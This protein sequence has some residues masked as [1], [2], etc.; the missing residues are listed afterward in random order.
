MCLLCSK[1]CNAVTAMMAQKLGNEDAALY[2]FTHP[3]FPTPPATPTRPP[4]LSNTV[5]ERNPSAQ[6]ISPTSS[7]QQHQ[8]QHQQQQQQQQQQDSSA[9]GDK[10]AR[11]G[12]DRL[13]AASGVGSQAVIKRQVGLGA[14]SHPPRRQAKATQQY[15]AG[16]AKI[17]IMLA[18]IKVSKCCQSLRCHMLKPFTSVCHTA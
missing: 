6:S 17:P 1:K 14:A 2:R 18:E 4:A 5:V 12:A 16:S 10:Q 13:Q 11:P 8:Q 7:Q 15:A 9:S 3:P